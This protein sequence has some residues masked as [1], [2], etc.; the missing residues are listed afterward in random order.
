MTSVLGLEHKS[1]QELLD[2]ATVVMFD[3]TPVSF[4]DY[5]H[6]ILAKKTSKRPKDLLDIEELGKINGE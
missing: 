2:E 1:F 6:L 4:I 3:K 5:Y